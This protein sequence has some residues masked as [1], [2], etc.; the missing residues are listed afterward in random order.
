MYV[1][2]CVCVC[3]CLCVLLCV[4]GHRSDDAAEVVGKR[5]AMYRQR[6][7]GKLWLCV[8][9]CKHIYIYIY[10]YACVYVAVIG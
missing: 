3:V 1:R 5:I 4:C 7:M 6:R 2:T 9:V 10:I 8:C